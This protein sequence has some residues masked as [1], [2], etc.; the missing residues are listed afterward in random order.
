K[1]QN[2]IKDL[3]ASGQL[4]IFA[5][6]YWGHPAMKLPPEVNLI[7][8]AHYL[9]ALECQRDANRVVALLGGKTPHI[10]NLAVGGVANPI[11][12]DG[13]GVLNLERLMY[14]KS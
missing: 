14:I 4:G 5:N 8:V 12:L 13:L 7:V 1:V 9:Q 2:K 11:N 3:V 6:G 10:Q